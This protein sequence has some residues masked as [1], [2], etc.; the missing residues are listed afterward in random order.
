MSDGVKDCSFCHPKLPPFRPA[1]I[2][3]LDTNGWSGWSKKSLK[4][5]ATEMQAEIRRLQ[6][7]RAHLLQAIQDHHDAPFQAEDHDNYLY[8]IASGIKAPGDHQERDA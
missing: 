2:W 6:R 3:D 4:E 1:P 5:L 8:A 7:D